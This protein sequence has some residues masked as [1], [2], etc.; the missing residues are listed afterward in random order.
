MA[1]GLHGRVRSSAG[2]LARTQAELDSVMGELETARGG[3]DVAERE[4][5]ALRGQVRKLDNGLLV[6]VFLSSWKKGYVL[7]AE[8]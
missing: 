7:Q 5:A 8:H 1:A 3:R 4:V 2:A 6:T